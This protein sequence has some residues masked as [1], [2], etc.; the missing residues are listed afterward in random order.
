MLLARIA[1]VLVRRAGIGLPILLSC[2]HVGCLSG[3]SE[4]GG[5]GFCSEM[6][7]RNPVHLPL[8]EDSKR[9]L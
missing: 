2:R 3:S 8:S 5:V 6:T 9:I 7:T 4:V 1:A